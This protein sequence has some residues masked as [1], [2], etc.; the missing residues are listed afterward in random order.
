MH[1]III[2]SFVYK[3]EKCAKRFRCEKHFFV[4]LFNK[5]TYL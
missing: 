2:N 1:D 3:R 4:A 5:V